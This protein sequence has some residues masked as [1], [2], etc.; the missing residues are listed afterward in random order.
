MK[1]TLIIIGF[2][3][4]NF[5]IAQYQS[6]QISTYTIS[7]IKVDFTAKNYIELK[8]T[9][10]KPNSIGSVILSINSVSAK[11]S[12]PI[13]IAVS[14]ENQLAKE[15]NNLSFFEGNKFQLEYY[16][17]NGVR[18]DLILTD[19]TGQ[20]FRGVP[21]MKFEIQ[22]ATTKKIG[23]L[24]VGYC[25][26]SNAIYKIHDTYFEVLERGGTTLTDCGADEDYDYFDPV[27]G[28]FYNQQPAKK[29]HYQITQDKKGFWLWTDESHKL[30][31]TR[32][33]LSVKENVLKE[34]VVISP[35]PANTIIHINSNSVELSEVSILD[36]QGR[37]IL[38]KKT[39]LNSI[40]ISKLSSGVYFIKLKSNNNEYLSKKI[41]KK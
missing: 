24:L 10:L 36:F 3:I 29:T 25:N 20:R 30:Y 6:I 38:H 21:T 4:V 22:D 11:P 1:K 34:A 31:F 35:N 14:K 23:A 8:N 40:D 9:V 2:F 7:S 27:T 17:K 13:R 32:K 15:T 19:L 28:N 18:E 12:S 39:N 37:I 26:V 41:V 5:S 33:V 16:L